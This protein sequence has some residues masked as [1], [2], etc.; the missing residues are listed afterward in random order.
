MEYKH[1][2]IENLSKTY[3]HNKSEIRA[4]DDISLNFPSIGLVGIN[5]KSG[6]GKTTLL[7]IL[8]G[9]LPFDNGK[10][11]IFGEDISKWTEEKFDNYRQNHISYIFQDFNFIFCPCITLS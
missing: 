1:L 11:F 10:I 9:F 6:S 2:T 3:M 8:A 5:G 4:L 7:Q